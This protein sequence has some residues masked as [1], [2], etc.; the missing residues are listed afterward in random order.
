MK[1]IVVF[2][3]STN[4]QRYTHLHSV[5]QAM[6]KFLWGSTRRWRQEFLAKNPARNLIRSLVDLYQLGRAVKFDWAP[7]MIKCNRKH[8]RKSQQISTFEVTPKIE[9]ENSKVLMH[10]TDN[11]ASFLRFITKEFVLEATRHERDDIWW[12]DRKHNRSYYDEPHI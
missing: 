1:A 3:I 6:Y 2:K 9:Y 4:R 7:K 11:F 8:V 12:N 10:L 5:C